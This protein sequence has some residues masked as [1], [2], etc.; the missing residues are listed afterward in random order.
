MRDD[1]KSLM[2]LLVVLFEQRDD[3]PLFLLSR[4]PVGSSARTRAGW[5]MRARPMETRCCCPP[6]SWLGRC[7]SRFPNAKCSAGCPGAF[8][9]LY[10]RPTKGQRNVFFYIQHGNQI[11]ELIDQADLTAA[12]N[13]QLRGIQL[14]DVRAVDID[15]SRGGTIHAAQQM[16]QGGLPGA[17]AADDRDKLAFSDGKRDVVNARTSVLPLP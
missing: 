11:V 14:I 16:E 7:P 12:K 4:F 5:L 1:Q 6:D 17:G 8:C 10:G 3:F 15:L 2:V 13:G 9:R